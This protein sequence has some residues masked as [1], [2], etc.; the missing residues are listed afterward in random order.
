MCQHTC[1]F[2][3]ITTEL[4]SGVVISE[5]TVLPSP[6]RGARRDFGVIDV[7]D[8]VKHLI[9][10]AVLCLMTCSVD[11]V[12]HVRAQYLCRRIQDLETADVG[13]VVVEFGRRDLWI[14]V[15]RLPVTQTTSQLTG[16]VGNVRD[17]FEPINSFQ[18]ARERG[19]I[20]SDQDLVRDVD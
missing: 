12:T 6:G 3:H 5:T 4:T 1:T 17:I 16:E 10:Q 18:L 7:P 9:H 14:P 19:V 15:Q 8:V 2:A 20:V 13:A 11:Q